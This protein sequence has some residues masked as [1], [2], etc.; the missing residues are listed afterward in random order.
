[1][2]KEA[3]KMIALGI[4]P[5]N[6]KMRKL[7]IPNLC[8]FKKELLRKAL[9]NRHS[10]KLE[11][12]SK[13]LERKKR[14]KLIANAIKNCKKDRNSITIPKSLR[15]TSWNSFVNGN[16]NNGNTFDNFILP[17]SDFEHKH[18]YFKELNE[19]I[20]ESDVLVEVLDCR[21][22]NGCRS[23]AIEKRIITSSSNILKGN[24]KLI[25]L[26]N[27]I[28]LI[29]T[30]I[31]QSWMHILRKEFAVIAFKASTQSQKRKLHSNVKYFGGRNDLQ[32]RTKGMS[33]RSIGANHLLQL[34]KNY[35]RS[36]NVKMPIKVGFI[37][38]PNTGK[39]SV[40]NTLKR[41]QS[42]GISALPGF[43][44]KLTEVKLDSN[45]I[46]IDS[47]GVIL[48]DG[49]KKTR[50]VLRNALKL[51]NIDPIEAI[52][53]ILS[54]ADHSSLANIY[55]LP[56]QQSITYHYSSVHTFLY[57]LAVKLNHLRTG[58]V[59]NIYRSAQTMIHD[60]NTGK[61][62]FYISPPKQALIETDTEVKIVDD[63]DEEFDVN[64]LLNENFLQALKI[65]VSDESDDDQ[66]Q[67]KFLKIEEEKFC[68]V[69]EEKKVDFDEI[70]N[71][72]L[73]DR[74]KMDDEEDCCV[75]DDD[76]MK[77]HAFINA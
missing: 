72:I 57:A 34:L 17:R 35:A 30:E 3:R 46:L 56:A 68:I 14:Q 8:P 10:L 50:L 15:S 16:R 11:L 67:K 53:H 24:K 73:V 18:L 29:P 63:F 39:S 47:P 36:F 60:W 1:M 55:Q 45:I 13:K 5:R 71:N 62:P 38:Y 74:N 6:Q 22:P 23:F 76:I 41:M 25:L 54:V 75:V 2:K 77:T 59:P 33:N 7:S 65:R 51:Q 9:K 43:T 26:L 37:G 21:D 42:V 27:K 12:E 64:A 52:A 44:K 58:G 49:E 31:L 70:V 4:R 19:I 61:I 48:N 32:L 40:I 69:S 20:A 66:N 28:D